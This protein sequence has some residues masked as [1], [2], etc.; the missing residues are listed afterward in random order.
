[1]PAGC[2]TI[3][4][5][6]DSD[7]KVL[8]YYF[9]EGKSNFKITSELFLRL[10]LD[11]SK[12]EY[13]LLK[14]Q[15]FNLLS[16]LYKF[17]GKLSRKTSGVIIGILLNEND[18]PEKF[19]SSLKESA[20]ALEIIGTNLLK[21][22]NKEFEPLLKD[23]YLEHLEP[24]IDILKPDALRASIINITKL[25]LSGGKNERKIAQDLLKK[26]EDGEHEKISEYYTNAESAL[27]SD[28][29]EKAAKFYKR[30]AEIA[31]ALY[32]VDIA[33]SLNE[34]AS[35][36]GTIPE[37][38]KH[39]DK[40]VQDA[41]NFLRNEDFHNAYIN[42]KKASELSKKLVEFD[43]EEEYRLKS[44]ALRSFYEIDQKFSKK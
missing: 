14:I 26:V 40:L 12:D 39:R 7:Y 27:K 10:N 25:M 13:N 23:I 33:E 17:K 6:L 37:I 4:L 38:S 41:R 43:K 1:M 11:H 19:R 5:P 2:F 22:K 18:K 44:D 20:E 34:K 3:L 24:L 15:D 36:S 30:A 32:I 42:Y 16:Y 29:Y 9:K 31:E 28:D 21:L 8:G 35:F